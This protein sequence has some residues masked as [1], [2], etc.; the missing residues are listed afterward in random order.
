MIATQ[1]KEPEYFRESHSFRSFWQSFREDKIALIS[2]YLFLAL[3]V[4][5]FLVGIFYRKT[6]NLVYG[7]PIPR[8][9]DAKEMREFMMS[10][11]DEAEKQ[12]SYEEN[13]EVVVKL[14]NYILPSL[15]LALLLIGVAFKT[16]ILLALFVVSILYIYILIS[17][18]KITKRYYKE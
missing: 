10:M 1:N 14:S 7:K 5:F 3:I 12:I 2:L 4:L 6:F 9:A 11:M 13:F 16:D 8:N 15:L 18:Y 17:Q